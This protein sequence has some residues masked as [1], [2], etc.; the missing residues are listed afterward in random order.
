MRAL[1]S[2]F[3]FF[4]ARASLLTL[5]IVGGSSIHNASAIVA[6]SMLRV[7]LLAF[8][9]VNQIHILT[10]FFARTRVQFLRVSTTKWGPSVSP[11]C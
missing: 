2:S 7:S 6:E 1:W 5:V 9:L 11:A 4:R 10:Y 8:F 3:I